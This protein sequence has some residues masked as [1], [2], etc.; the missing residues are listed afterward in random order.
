VG[1]DPPLFCL[2][3]RLASW[4]PPLMT[5][6][7][8]FPFSLALSKGVSLTVLFSRPSAWPGL[9]TFPYLDHRFFPRT[10]PQPSAF[11][12]P[13][14]IFFDDRV[15]SKI[16]LPRHNSTYLL[17][18]S[19]RPLQRDVPFGLLSLN[20]RGCQQS[21]CLSSASPHT[22]LASLVILHLVKTSFFSLMRVF[23]F[24][25]PAPRIPPRLQLHPPRSGAQPRVSPPDPDSF[26][27]PPPHPKPKVSV[28]QNSIDRFVFHGNSW[29]PT[30]RF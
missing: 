12:S 24:C 23:F 30:C 25:S 11:P 18:T 13:D 5:V 27:L 7:R 6:P 22:L 26:R 19:V 21:T 16:I 29:H 3:S 15:E 8:L 28:A 14:A 20:K 9:P 1:L 17:I 10:A 4:P 2:L